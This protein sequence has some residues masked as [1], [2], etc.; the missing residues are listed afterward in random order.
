MKLQPALSHIPYRMH[1]SHRLVLILVHVGFTLVLLAGC[2]SHA[3]RKV[4][5][6]GSDTMVILVQRWAQAFMRAHP[7]ISVQVAGGGTGTG[8]A[9]LISGT[10][11]LASASRKISQKEYDEILAKHGKAPCEHVVAIDALTIYV[12]KSNPVSSLSLEQVA[13]IYRGLI[14]DWS[15]VG[16]IRQPIVAYGRESS[17]GTYAYFKERVLRGADF[18][19]EVQTLAGT[20]AIIAAVS[21]DPAGIGYGG[22]GYAKGVKALAIRLED[23]QELMPSAEAAQSGTYPLARPL[24]FYS[25]GEAQGDIRR[26]IEFVRSLEGQSIAKASGFFE[27]P[28][29]HNLRNSP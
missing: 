3:R 23:G 8:I 7:E 20:A 22:V 9:A 21:T 18:A 17:S 1:P 10:A 25:I 28:A 27:V 5:I 24:F 15:E 12:H 4:V 11:D 29:I 19:D 2:D 13:G 14:R 26:F 16:G 6:R